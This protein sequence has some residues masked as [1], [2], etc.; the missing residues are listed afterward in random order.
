M[1]ALCLIYDIITVCEN[2]CIVVFFWFGSDLDLSLRDSVFHIYHYYYYYK[3][4]CTLN[5]VI[6]RSFS[7]G[8]CPYSQ[9]HCPYTVLGRTRKELKSP[10]QNP[11]KNE[12][13]TTLCLCQ[14]IHKFLNVNLEKQ[15]G[16]L[17]TKQS[18][19]TKYNIQTRLRTD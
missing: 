17:Y 8:H 16:F 3:H 10:R 9:G 5:A 14:L 11:E 19:Q 4:L 6:Q 7:Q 12:S 13:G 2:S 15:V 18:I 1:K